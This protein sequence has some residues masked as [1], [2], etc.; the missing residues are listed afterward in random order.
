M[1]KEHSIFYPITSYDFST[2][3]LTLTIYLIRRFG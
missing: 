2:E 1:G 3:T